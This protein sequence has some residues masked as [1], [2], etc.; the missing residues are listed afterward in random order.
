MPGPYP[1][2]K[3]AC[4]FF[5]HLF[6][7]VGISVYILLSKTHPLQALPHSPVQRGRTGQDGSP[8]AQGHEQQHTAVVMGDTRLVEVMLGYDAY[9]N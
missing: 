3:V 6:R 1:H 5:G 8:A 9:C 4:F 2:V 7:T